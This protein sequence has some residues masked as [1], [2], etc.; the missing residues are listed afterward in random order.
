MTYARTT[1][2]VYMVSARQFASK[3]N[4]NQVDLDFDTYENTHNQM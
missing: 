4:K 1:T 2:F 3:K